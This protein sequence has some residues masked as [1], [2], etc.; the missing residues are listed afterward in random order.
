MCVSAVSI[1]PSHFNIKKHYYYVRPL[2][3]QIVKEL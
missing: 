1:H 2:I 3:V